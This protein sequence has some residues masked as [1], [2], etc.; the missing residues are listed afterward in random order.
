MLLYKYLA[1]IK[2]IYIYKYIKIMREKK[3]FSEQEMA[4][5]N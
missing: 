5:E 2:V 4:N 1:C 3:F